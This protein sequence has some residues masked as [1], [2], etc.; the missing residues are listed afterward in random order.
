[1]KP[2]LSQYESNSVVCE[3][4]NIKPQTL[5]AY[6]SRG[7]LRTTADPH[8]S[9]KSLYLT[10]DVDRLLARKTRGRSRQAIAASTIDSGEP[11]L[12]SS[13]TEINNGQFY[14]RGKNA[15]S[16]SQSASL[17]QTFCLLCDTPESNLAS[18]LK[19]ETD[20]NHRNPF[21]RMLHITS[22]E[23][24]AAKGLG[25]KQYAYQLL[26]KLTSAAA[27]KPYNSKEPIHNFLAR[28]WSQDSRAAE[29]IR[30]AL[31][32][33]AD[34]EL[35]AST[36]ASR[37]ATSAGAT[38]ASSIL[39]G[40]A[41]LSGT[42]HGGLTD[43]CFNWMR[44]MSKQYDVAKIE[45]NMPNAKI[46]AGFGQPLYPRGDPRATTIIQACKPRDSWLE[47]VTLIDKTTGKH[48][49]L[50]FGLATLEDQLNMKRGSGFGIFAVGRTVG[51]MAHYFEQRQSNKIIRPRSSPKT[52]N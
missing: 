19:V 9:R 37:V 39:V 27:G 20:S 11:I 48:P 8:D 2:I 10:E 4:L 51:W 40:L 30:Q 13:I 36:Y 43:Q 49:S 41:T 52:A 42:R 18:Q 25:T 46:P 14:Y 12:T 31:V 26:C 23:C 34:H 22:Q 50:D 45:L 1:M 17:E 21:T 3:R 47:L 35:N 44:K 24:L 32:L 38:L 29:L 33:S 7:L 16:Y 6:V 28:H 5:Y 15:L